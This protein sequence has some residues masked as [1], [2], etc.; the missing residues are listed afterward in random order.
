M[1]TSPAWLALLALTY[2]VSAVWST[3]LG[4]PPPPMLTC[5]SPKLSKLP[6][7]DIKLSFEERVA[8]LLPRLNISDKIAQT[9]MVAG[10]VPALAMQ[11]YNFGGK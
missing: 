3:G 2:G 5:Q 8:D 10:S 4:P 11:Q 6:F 1:A 7:C 9:G